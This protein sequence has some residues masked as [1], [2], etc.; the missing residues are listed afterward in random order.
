MVDASRGAGPPQ[1]GTPAA[2]AGGWRRQPAPWR[3]QLASLSPRS[4]QLP[5][6]K[7]R[8]GRGGERGKKKKRK[9]KRGGGLPRATGERLLPPPGCWAAGKL[10]PEQRRRCPQG[11]GEE[12]AALRWAAGAGAGVRSPG[13]GR[14]RHGPTGAQPTI[15]RPAAGAR[16]APAAAAAAASGA[17][18]PPPPPGGAEEPGAGPRGGGFLQTRSGPDGC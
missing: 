2:P 9:R 4:P 17:G 13:S 14:R 18:G 7:V 15:S 8:G 6:R 3:P 1:P 10:Q 16:S 5:G 11:C 12:E